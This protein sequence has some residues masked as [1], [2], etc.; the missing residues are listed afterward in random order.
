[1]KN[2]F[3]LFKG[4]LFRLLKYKILWFGLGLSLIWILVL[5]LSAQ[6]EAKALM[7]YLLVMDTGMMAI[8]LLSS[9]FYYEK[10]EN[11]IKSIFVSPV[12]VGQILVVKILSSL[13]MSVGSIILVGL[14]M[15]IVHGVLINYLLAI[16][17]VILSTLAHVAIG[18]IIVFY[19]IDF[20]SFLMKYMGVVLILMLPTLLVLL[21][22]VGSFGE[23]FALLSPSYAIQFLIGSLFE[24]TDIWK[25]VISVCTLVTISAVLYPLVVYPKF[26]AFAI[27]G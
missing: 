16:I 14:T 4:E 19:S 22:L 10:Q 23:Y 17:Y 18:Y 26:K 21:N 15:L 25:I 2:L 9:S 13:V 24:K 11:T 27:R 20:T 12:L 7:P 3:I 5:S 8:I 1:M 6:A